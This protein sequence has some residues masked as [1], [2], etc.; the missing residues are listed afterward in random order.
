MTRRSISNILVALLLFF[1]VITTTGVFAT[2]KYATES[3]A[4]V[5]H[6]VSVSLM[7][8]NYPPGEILPGGDNEEAELGSDH[9]YLIDLILNEDSKGYG[10]NI[11]DNVLLHQYLNQEEVVYSNQKISGGN[12]KFIIDPKNN[13]HKLYYCIQKIS[14]TEYHSF[15]FSVD[16][17]STASGSNNEIVAYKTILEK[18]DI[19][20]A[21][22]SYSGYAK[23][24]S[25]TE[26]GVSA[27]PNTISYSI[28]VATWHL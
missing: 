27:D 20:R 8:F 4:P 23:V 10:L 22:K 11:N 28:D 19:W 1:T 3:P 5:Q 25:L 9:Y 21:T 13:T 16:D 6:D 2:W 24:K 18:T 17:L 12:L 14:N 26:F 7:V 15:T